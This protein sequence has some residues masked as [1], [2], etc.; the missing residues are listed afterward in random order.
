MNYFEW[1]LRGFAYLNVGLYLLTILLAGPALV[2]YFVFKLIR[3]VRM[4]KCMQ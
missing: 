1:L 2:I 4:R 3:R